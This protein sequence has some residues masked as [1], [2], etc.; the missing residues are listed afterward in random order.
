MDTNDASTTG[1]WDGLL[2]GASLATL[3]G[4]GYGEIGDGALAWRDGLL[5]Y[6]GPRAEL[7]GDPATLADEV[8][9]AR[10]WVTPG[11]VDCHTHLVFAGDRAREFEMRLQGASYEDIARA[12]GGI[13]STVRAVRAA[14]EAGLLRQSLPRARALLADGATT[15]EIKSGYGL[16]FDNERKM[17]RVARQVG[18]ELGIDVRTTY[19]AAHAL[20]PEFK[21]RPDAY[22]DA[23][24]D[25]LPRLH[26]EGLVDAVDAFCEGI[27]FSPEQTRRVFEA[28]R[29]LGLPVKLHADQLSDLG[30]AGLVAEFGGLSADHVEHTSTDSV[31]AMAASGAVAVLLPGA[32]HVLRETKL[33]PLDAFREHGVPMAVATDCNP[34]TSPLLS[35]RQAMQLACT[36]FRL[37]PE[38]ALRGATVH[39]ARALGLADRGVLRAG[40]RADFACW[41]IGHPSEL[42]YWLGGRLATA[43]HI[44]GRRLA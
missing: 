30:G 22:I 34:G 28:A 42:G 25:W 16:D 36:H 1:R 21:D 15:L 11:L 33:P 12:G 41:D 26:G 35:M 6:V 20:P 10:G 37:T 39:A 19:L 27:G 43:V 4:D 29:G 5:A 14:D 13:V 7:P 8:I 9:E 38:E 17:L 31:R 23:V 40:M 2:L 24:I 3:D 18:A 32:F 44:G